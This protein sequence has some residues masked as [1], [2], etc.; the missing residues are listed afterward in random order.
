[1]VT[2]VDFIYAR[3][4]TSE[5]PQ[6]PFSRIILRRRSWGWDWGPVLMTVGPWKPIYLHSYAHRITDLRITSNVSEDLSVTGQ[7]TF[8]LN[9]PAKEGLKIMTSIQS[10]TDSQ[11]VAQELSAD[12]G[13]LDFSFKAEEVELWFPIGYGKPALHTFTAALIDKVY[14]Y[15]LVRLGLPDSACKNGNVYD[16]QT[17]TI[18]FR[19]AQLIQ[20]EL[21]DQDG[22][23]FFF[24][25][26]N[27][28]IFCGGS[29][30]IPADS[31]LTTYVLVNS[32]SVAIL[33]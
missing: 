17:K 15:P 12:A 23:S 30:W 26:N 22:L 2:A 13:K 7:V 6:V 14:I 8:K 33:S 27:I 16:E 9:E 5:L 25:I 18:G 29:N 10:A 1:M 31:F 3:P 20:R 32:V 24:E 11:L 28:P 21:I 19:R 4:S